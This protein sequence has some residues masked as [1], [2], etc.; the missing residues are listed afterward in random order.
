MNIEN[1]NKTKKLTFSAIVIAIYVIL[2]FYTQSFAF[3]AY[4]VRIATSLYALSYIFPFL[5]FPLGL[6][7]FLSNTLMGGMGVFDMVGGFIVGIITTL[8]IVCIKKFRLNIW[9]VGLPI[10][11]IPA[12]GVAT[13]LSYILKIP[14]S[15]LALSLCIGQILPAVCGVVLVK[16]LLKVWE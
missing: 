8:L 10:L 9:F 15:A 7:N 5:V 16:A 6:A 11:F 4:Q 13:W 14:Y 2:M 3:G 1:I 12:F